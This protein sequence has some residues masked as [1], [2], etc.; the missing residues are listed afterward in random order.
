M[1]ATL[2]N[3]R[4]DRLVARLTP[5]DKALLEQAA[6]LEGTS[7]ASFVVSH[8]RAAAEKLIFEHQVI[9]LDMKESR[10]FVEALLAP[11][12]PATKRMKQ[13]LADY[14]KTVTER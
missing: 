7:V 1:T 6:N 8:T 14:R 2:K 9:R 11:P 3:R 10:R 13:A 12:R 4:T 5:A